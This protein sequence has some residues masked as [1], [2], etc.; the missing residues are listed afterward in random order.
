MLHGVREEIGVHEDGIR[1]HKGGVVLVKERRGNLGDFA[2]DF[3]GFGSREFLSFRE[4]GRL[5]LFEAGIP[6]ADQALDLPKLSGFLCTAH[7]GRALL[8]WSCRVIWLWTS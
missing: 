6:L 4:G 7:A 8:T 3:L 2:D 1:G 5:I